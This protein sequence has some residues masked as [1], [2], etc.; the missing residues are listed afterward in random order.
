M[1]ITI[2]LDIPELDKLM[3][4]QQ[5]LNALDTELNAMLNA[6][7]N[8]SVMDLLPLMDKA[9]NTAAKLAGQADYTTQLQPIARYHFDILMISFYSR[10]TERYRIAGKALKNPY[11]GSY[12]KAHEQILDRMKADG[13]NSEAINAR[14]K[15]A[16][17]AAFNE[18]IESIQGVHDA[19]T[20]N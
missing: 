9:R 16:V 5:E 3:P 12:S 2:T 19:S 10:L 18:Q 15:E 13:Y 7:H 11:I 8:I 4:A 1:Q 6:E 20:G 14:I 17:Q